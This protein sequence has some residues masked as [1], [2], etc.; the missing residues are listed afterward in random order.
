MFRLLTR[1][2]ALPVLVVITLP[3][4]GCS[5]PWR[6]G[7]S[8]PAVPIA[9]GTAASAPSGVAPSGSASP[10]PAS[11]PRYA[12]FY[13]QKPSWQDCQDGAEC[14][15]VTVPIDWSKPDGATATLAAIRVRATGKKI[16]SLFYN[17]GGPGV[18]TLDL[19]ASWVPSLPD[20]VQAA[21][22]LVGWD[23]RGVG[24]SRPAI[25][26]LPNEDLD[27]YYAEDITPDS[28]A[29]RDAM[30]ASVREYAGACEKGTGELLA[31]L[32]TISTAHDM[33]VLRAVVGDAKL[34]YFGASYGTFMGAWY[35][36]TFPQRVGRLV[37][38]GAVDPSL[39]APEYNSGQAT[40]FGRAVRAYV[41]DCLSQR[42]CPLT[43]TREQAYAQ[44]E[45]LL[46]RADTRPLTGGNG[47]P[48]TEALLTTGL[49]AGLYSSSGWP[50]VTRT[51]TE[52]KAGNGETARTLADLYLERDDTGQYGPT[53]QAFS[54]IFCLDR[55]ETRSVAEI[56]ADAGTYDD[57]FPPFGSSFGWSTLVCKDW[58]YPQVTP[59]RPLRAAGAAPILV[60]GTT[61]DPATP[62]EW[63]KGLA[64][65]LESGR[66]LTR[67]GQGHTGYQMGSECTDKAINAYLLRG[68]LPAEGTICS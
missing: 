25:T 45:Q 44:I 27:A 6:G 28:P 63:A 26:C 20:A 34:T 23:T 5:L 61:D 59:T 52:A 38:D 55:G 37:L 31:H 65:Q 22:D 66:L 9:S 49:I 32:D 12:R 67:K 17:P 60:V 62:Y 42:S 15:S 13:D 40:G 3:L 2:R 48:V 24:A 41:D 11:D 16:G 8:G 54:A 33:D 35:A 43:G 51:I 64:S 46:Q 56:E 58:P 36:E 18:S 30:E 7:G 39:P 47:R 29:E 50:A 10:D 21:Y 14:A 53:M 19:F 68:T 1:S 4:V 57:R